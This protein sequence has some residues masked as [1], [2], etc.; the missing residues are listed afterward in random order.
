MTDDAAQRLAALRAKRNA[1]ATDSVFA[2]PPS[3]AQSPKDSR[4]T[5]TSTHTAVTASPGRSAAVGTARARLVV[6]TISGV[7]FVATIA[8]MGPIVTD[9]DGEVVEATGTIDPAAKAANTAASGSFADAQAPVVDVISNYIYVDANGDPLSEAEVAALRTEPLPLAAQADTSA[10]DAVVAAG[11]TTTVAPVVAVPTASTPAAP[12]PVV[13]QPPATA[14][15]G[16]VVTQ[17]PATAAPAPV[18][19][20]GHATAC[21]CGSGTCGHATACYCGSGTCGHPTAA[22]SS[23]SSS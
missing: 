15:P 2:A 21:Y 20:C 5:P 14:A 12:A 6:G 8:A 17:P 9:S 1:A 18:G 22:S 23:S 19:T 7:G 11:P 4:P 3:A 10:P 13:T 16:P